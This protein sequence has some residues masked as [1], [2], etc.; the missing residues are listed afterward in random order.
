[1]ASF[2]VRRW[3]DLSLSN[4]NLM[5]QFSQYFREGYFSQALAL[6]MNNDDID[7]ESVAPIC[8]NM[9]HT[10]LEYLQNLYYNA[11]EVKLAE[12]EQ[13]FQTMLNNY[14]N[15]K[16]YQAD[17]QYEMY[18]FAV[19]DKQVYMCLKQS[20]GNL[21]TDTEYWVLIGLKG[22]VGAT[23]I[24][25]QLK[26][27]WNK[28]VSY[29]INDVVTYENIMYIALKANINVQPDTTPSTWQVFMKFPRAR[30]IV[31]EVMPSNELLEVGGQWW[32]VKQEPKNLWEVVVKDI[33]S[34]KSLE[35]ETSDFSSLKL[36]ISQYGDISFSGEFPE[37]ATVVTYTLQ[38]GDG[39]S[40]LSEED[41]AIL[42]KF[43]S[44]FL[45]G[46]KFY[47]YSLNTS[48]N[49]NIIENDSFIVLM[50]LQFMYL[51]DSSTTSYP[52]SIESNFQKPNIAD[53]NIQQSGLT[54]NKTKEELSIPYMFRM[55]IGFQKIN[56]NINQVIKPYIWTSDTSMI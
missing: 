1:M 38:I 34:Y 3:Q 14:I 16:E 32:R 21:P 31:S 11:V 42:T 6:I 46:G 28:T 10:A 37:N 33:L 50:Q 26:N 54:K 12:D 48:L 9:I 29:A 5:Q 55:A 49:Q 20:T 27:V 44:D 4:R 15:K 2:E 45:E 53:K 51:S 13:L 19:Y 47:F 25:V 8:F 56:F 17:V 24:D 22:E 41:K 35:P 39:H 36:N 23:S 7:S 18:N 40:S 30:V 52:I 43:Y